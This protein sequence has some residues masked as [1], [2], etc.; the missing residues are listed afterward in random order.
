[1]RG[2]NVIIVAGTRA[3][4]PACLPASSLPCPASCRLPGTNFVIKNSVCILI[5]QLL[6]GCFVHGLY[7]EGAR[8]DQSTNQLQR[9]R[10]KVLVEELGI[11]AVVPIEAHRLKLQVCMHPNGITKRG[12]KEKTERVI[13]G[14]RGG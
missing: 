10:P 5:V 14:E 2:V 1:M 4:C 7:I 9:S 13:E 12:Q 6:Q 8:F 11:L 3:H